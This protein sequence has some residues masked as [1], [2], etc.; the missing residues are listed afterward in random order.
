[1]TSF[2]WE[3]EHN[4]TDFLLALREAVVQSW[5]FIRFKGKHLWW[6]PFFNIIAERNFVK[7][8]IQT[9]MLSRKFCKYFR[10]IYC[11]R[12]PPGDFFWKGYSQLIVILY[13]LKIS[14]KN[15]RFLTSS[16]ILKRNVG[17]KWG[18]EISAE[19]ES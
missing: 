14:K 6:S 4:P 15:S 5:K 3:D 10:K 16:W 19:S 11:Y 18:N 7:K 1:M 2:C 13:P 9:V 12:A 8:E 17:L